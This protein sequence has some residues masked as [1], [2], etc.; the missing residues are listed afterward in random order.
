MSVEGSQQVQRFLK[1][2]GSYD[3][4]QQTINDNGS[5]IHKRSLVTVTSK[6]LYCSA[7]RFLGEESEQTNDGS[8]ETERLELCTVH[9]SVPSE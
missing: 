4:F 8:R 5:C 6:T 1:H 7:L 2:N 9:G 3:N